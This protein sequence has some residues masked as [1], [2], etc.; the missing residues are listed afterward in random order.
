M[1][2]RIIYIPR[3]K[4]RK[5]LEK[6]SREIMEGLDFLEKV[7]PLEPIDEESFES[8][9]RRLTL[10][11]QMYAEDGDIPD[12]MIDRVIASAK[13]QSNYEQRY[14]RNRSRRGRAELPW[15]N[16]SVSVNDALRLAKAYPCDGPN[17]ARNNESFNEASEDYLG[18]VCIRDSRGEFLDFDEDILSCPRYIHLRFRRD[19]GCA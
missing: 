6:V 15:R 19:L 4:A 10:G 13:Q 12:W 5:L 1:S 2:K 16:G 18:V 11:P 3:G 14:R 17:A 8:M 7:G 9:R